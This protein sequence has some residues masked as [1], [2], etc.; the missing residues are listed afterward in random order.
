MAIE[1]EA[2]AKELAKIQTYYKDD[3]QQSKFNVLLMGESGS[4]KSYFS[5][6]CR[7]P[8]HFDSFD[9][10]GTKCV[11]RWIEEG[12]IIADTKYEAEDPK[13]P[14][15]FE[16][17]KNDF[18]WREKN[19]YFK[20]FGTYF[21]DSSTTWAMSIMNH[22]L[23]KAGIAGDAPRFTKDYTPQKVEIRNWMQRILNLPCDVV[24]TGHLKLDEDP[25]KGRIF[26][27][28]TTGDGAIVIPLMFDELWVMRTKETSQ[29]VEYQLL[30]KS[31]GMYMA[32][33]RLASDG[34]IETVEKPDMKELRKKVK[35]SIEDKPLFK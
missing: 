13:H 33:S 16:K 14:S 26:R 29:G 8:I 9:P 17:W 3:P 20:M 23:K 30:T 21:L 35:L 6:T 32:R 18:D 19:G 1:N 25:D 15:A 34:K 12:K 11:R 10:G 24:V 27:Y 2:L 5:R 7:F 31:T 22:I 28:M 4:G